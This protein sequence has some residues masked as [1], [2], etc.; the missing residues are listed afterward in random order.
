MLCQN[1]HKNLASVRYA[2][3]VDGKVSDLH[4]CQDCLAARAGSASTGFEFSTP[5]PFL[6]KRKD[7]PARESGE[8]RQTCTACV[9]SLQ[10]IMDTGKV[11]C[12]VCYESFPAELEA[13][14]EGIHIALIHRGKAP[15]IDDARVR[16]R[17]DLQSKRALLK[18]A[19]SMENY[20]EAASL[21]DE[22][23][24]LEIG[25][26]ASEAGVD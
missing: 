6:G 2:E 22:I 12:S 14:L 15:R 21:R 19:L 16:V 3:V 7:P 26:G 25:L 17:S 13:L 4:L 10:E 24:A 5:S 11:G 20:E 8:G 18:T 9:M 1:C 23:R